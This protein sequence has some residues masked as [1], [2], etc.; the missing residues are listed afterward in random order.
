M[1]S[2][3]RTRTGQFGLVACVLAG[4]VVVNPSTAAQAAVPFYGLRFFSL[5]AAVQ[6][7]EPSPPNGGMIA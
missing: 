6:K 5:S 3:R 7:D 2:H 1:V 4:T